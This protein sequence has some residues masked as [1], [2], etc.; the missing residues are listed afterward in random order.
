VRRPAAQRPRRARGAARGD[1]G[2]VQA[3]ALAA[4]SSWSREIGRSA[5]EAKRPG[6]A[7]PLPLLEA[8]DKQALV[9]ANRDRRARVLP[10]LASLVATR[11]PTGL[12]A[13][14]PR[15]RP[16][17]DADRRSERE[18]ARHPRPPRA[19]ADLPANEGGARGHARA[20]RPAR[21]PAN[22]LPVRERPNQT[23]AN[24]GQQPRRDRE[25]TQR[26]PHPHRPRRPPL[27][28]RN[29]PLHHQPNNL[30]SHPVENAGNRDS[31]AGSDR[32]RPG[33]G[34]A[35]PARAQFRYAAVTRRRR[36]VTQV[37]AGTPVVR[38]CIKVAGDGTRADG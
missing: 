12:G 30:T 18:P 34:C 27:V 2:R 13:G 25:R 10:D 9:A 24:S 8:A 21:T 20:G 17:A 28:P 16:R 14:R 19:A 32:G 33:G 3:P 22:H 36:F 11:P 4:C 26:R 15:L 6:I 37:R 31:C 35:R 23:R 5:E 1:R 38:A 7:E 29:H